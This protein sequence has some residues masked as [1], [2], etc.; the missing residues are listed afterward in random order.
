MVSNKTLDRLLKQHNLT[1]AV[2][3]GGMHESQY[4]S[5]SSGFQDFAQ[6]EVEGARSYVCWFERT[7]IVGR[8]TLDHGLLVHEL[9]HAAFPEGPRD[10]WRE[11]CTWMYAAERVLAGHLQMVGAWEDY[12]EDTPID[13]M[14]GSQTFWKHL[15]RKEQREHMDTWWGFM[16]DEGIYRDKKLVLSVWPDQTTTPP[17]SRG[18]HVLPPERSRG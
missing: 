14:Y 13:G 12:F 16:M 3:G 8:R 6:I 18:L 7:V 4:E 10:N 1:L 17:L 9:M 15:T 2:Y 11:S 5:W